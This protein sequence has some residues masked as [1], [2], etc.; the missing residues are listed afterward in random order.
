MSRIRKESV[1]LF[2]KI[3][4]D[5]E[6]GKKC[7]ALSNKL[8]AT[9]EALSEFVRKYGFKGWQN[10]ILSAKGSIVACIADE[11]YSPDMTVWK[12]VEKES[13]KYMPRLNTKAGKA[14]RKEINM[15]PQVK[16]SEINEL[17]GYNSV[18]VEHIGFSFQKEGFYGITLFDSW[19]ITMPKDAIPIFPIEYKNLFQS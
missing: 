18:S 19:D 8:V 13:R 12:I 11:S 10:G 6:L 4:A 9:H 2:Y 14:I 17:V 16:S 3:P 15:L 1:E 7:E 5:S